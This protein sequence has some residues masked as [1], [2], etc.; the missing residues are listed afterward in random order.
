[1]PE[2]KSIDDVQFQIT[3]TGRQAYVLITALELL[4]RI[5]M[6]QVNEIRNTLGYHEI[7]RTATLERH[8]QRSEYGKIPDHIYRGQD[9]RQLGIN[10]ADTLD[11]L[12]EVI[13][14]ELAPNESWGITNPEIPEDARIAWDL[15]QV[16]R[17]HTSWES[18]GWPR[19]RDWSTM[20]TVNYDEPMK[21]SGDEPLAK[22]ETIS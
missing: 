22:M 7:P 13:F 6:G 8:I 15:Y 9:Y 19:K 1:M 18:V 2:L 14:P 20:I 4:S 11:H 16:I 17:H 5:H 21:T 3:L 10:I 12:K